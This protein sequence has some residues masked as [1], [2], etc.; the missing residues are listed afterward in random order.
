MKP[1]AVMLMA[2][3]EELARKVAPLLRDEL[4][5]QLL[6]DLLRGIAEQLAPQLQAAQELAFARAADGQLVR[7][8][9]PKWLTLAQAMERAGFTDRRAFFEAM[10]RLG[11]RPSKPSPRKTFFHPDDIEDAIARAQMNPT[12]TRRQTRISRQ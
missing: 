12:R 4:R 8:P 6:P 7:P 9:K 1:Q 3:P 2:S 10:Q 11:V 5:A